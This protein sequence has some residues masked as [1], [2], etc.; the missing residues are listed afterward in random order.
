MES[1]LQTIQRI[2]EVY[3]DTYANLPTS[4]VMVGDLGYATDRLVLYRWSGAAWEFLTFHFSS[5]LAAALPT[6]A[7]LPNGS[8]YYETDT[9]V[10]QQ[11]QAGAWASIN[12]IELSIL[13]TDEDIIVR[14]AGTPARLA[15][16]ANGT[17]LGVSAGVVG[18]S[19][20]PP[21]AS[22]T[23]VETEV[24]NSTSPGTT[25]TDLDLSGTVGAQ[26]TLVILKVRGQTGAC[27]FRKNGD[28]DEF[29]SNTEDEKA[30]GCALTANAELLHNVFVVVT[31]ASGIVEWKTEYTNTTTVDVMAYIK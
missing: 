4:G 27:A 22:L 25:Y 28:T 12:T 23:I 14:K 26:V 15:K 5:G 10:T 30:R 2:R 20:P 24:F 8:V 1:D 11:V 6:A 31:D 17:Y 16:G 29:W 19:T 21:S 18:Y 13:T 7:D 9:L 3:R